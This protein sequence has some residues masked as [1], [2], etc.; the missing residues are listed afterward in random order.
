M[1]FL[2]PLFA[3]GQTPAYYSTYLKEIGLSGADQSFCYETQKVQ[4][5][6]SNESKKM[7]PASVTKLYVTDWLLSKVSKDLRFETKFYLKDK[8]LFILGGQDSFFVT[9]SVTKIIEHLNANQITELDEIIFDKY[10][11]LNWFDT[12]VD[13]SS[14]IL[15]YFNLQ[16]MNQQLSPEL[17]AIYQRNLFLNI[18]T[19]PLALKMKVKKVSFSDSITVEKPYLSF[20]FF[21]SPVHKHIKQMNIYSTNFM[22]QKLFD[23]L[24]G[25]E[26]FHA[27]IKETYNKDASEIYF[28]TG[29]GLGENYTTCEITIEMLKHL[30]KT[31][32]ESGLR[33]QD[34]VSV[35]GTDAGTLNQR[36]TEAEYKNLI[37]A[38][39][40]TLKDRTTLA[41]FLSFDSGIHYFTIFNHTWDLD[42]GRKF[43]NKLIKKLIASEG[44]RLPFDYQKI[45]YSPIEDVIIE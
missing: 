8:K 33:I 45:E 16:K 15:K 36:F 41:G 20:S 25:I 35:A 21:S 38:K 24:G 23:Y 39:T 4:L 40:G 3:W 44:V 32:E 11:Y 6:K 37:R 42:G 27:Y 10:F 43:Q 18:E 14:Q 34:V 30:E 31:I 2:V 9:E 12:P 7:K 28:Y 22:A 19:N 5:Y 1:T 29:S 26:S 13:V 17:N